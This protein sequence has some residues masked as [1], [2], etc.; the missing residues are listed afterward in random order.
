[1]YEF[2]WNSKKA[3]L[4]PL[5]NKKKSSKTEGENF[6]TI[7]KGHLEEHCKSYKKLKKEDE[8]MV[9]IVLEEVQPLLAKFV[10]ITPSKMVDRLL[11]LRDVQHHMDLVCNFTQLAPLLYEPSRTYNFAST[12]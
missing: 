4:M 10:D 8:C 5:T 11:P 12:T 6:L 9:K 3:R 7:V 2:W 1:M